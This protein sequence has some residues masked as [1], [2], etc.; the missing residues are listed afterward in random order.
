MHRQHSHLGSF[1]E[2][3]TLHHVHTTAIYPSV[4]L[5]PPCAKEEATHVLMQVL[6]ELLL[7]R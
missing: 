2:E 7:V 1:P 3:P 6:A 4:E 5:L